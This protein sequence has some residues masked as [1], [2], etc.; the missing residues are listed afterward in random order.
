MK[1]LV[2]SLPIYLGLLACLSVARGEEPHSPLAK[3][4]LQDGDSIVFLGDSIT[5]QCLY[6]QYVEDFF[7]TRFP[8]M[9]LKFHNAGVGG[10]K[11]WDALQRFDA[12]VAAYKPKYV[13]V[14]LGMNDGR[15][16]P[17]DEEIFRTYHRD[18][19][20]LI[21]RLTDIDATPILMTPTMFD[22]RAARLG[23]RQHDPG[24]LELYNAVLAYYGTWLREVAVENGYGFVDM[25]SP[26]NNLTIAQRK[27]DASFTLIRD[28]VHP[29][30]PGQLV[31]AYAIIEDLGLRAP[32]S[33][34]RLVRKPDGSF[35]DV[36]N[37]GKLS[38]VKAN[39]DGV[40]FS[41][42][43]KGLPYVV[44]EEARL[45]AKLL[46]LGHRAS[47][48]AL[49]VHGL[50]PGN[51]ELTIDGRSVGVFSHVMLSRHIE[52]QENS[53]TPQYQQA[54]K[55]A[56]LNK[57]RNAGPVRS[58][59]NEWRIFQQY[60]RLAEQL[61]ANADNDALQKLVAAQKQRLEGM[62]TRVA[63]FQKAAKEIEDEIFEVNQP[64]ARSYV[65][66][67]VVPASV[68]G[69]VTLDGQ[70]LAGSTVTF[71]SE[72]GRAASAKV[73]AAGKYRLKAGLL[74]GKYRVTID[75][76]EEIEMDEKA[77]EDGTTIAPKQAAPS[78]LVVEVTAGGTNQ[79][80]FELTSD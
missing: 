66:R 52:L 80:Q 40:Q 62:E 55:V 35:G 20:A 46:R 27:S 73:D 10:A 4:D 44:P 28:A 5:H 65:L 31:M 57:Q 16:T 36:T 11:A 51:Y 75:Q 12:D 2:R 39:E 71:H 17:Y 43:A 58:L 74:P 26:L 33:N 3:L 1:S 61:K 47:R 70:P 19:T 24:K 49:E 37:G 41:W 76:G 63:G 72:S 69:Q 42:L 21:S 15:Y 50:K 34:I 45:G 53:Q 56:E 6:T 9:R 78:P 8:N 23:R 25:Y 64:V 30:A 14:L 54:A 77:R 48:E 22:S 68:T 67:R 79:F 7:Y 13:T 60:A 59:R 38:D 32:L 18:M 29:D